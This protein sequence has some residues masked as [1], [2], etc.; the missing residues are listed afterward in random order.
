MTHPVF[1]NKFEDDYDPP[2]ALPDDDTKQDGM[3]D[4]TAPIIKFSNV[5]DGADGLQV[6]MP[7]NG[8]GGLPDWFH[9]LR[10][11]PPDNQTAIYTRPTSFER[12]SDSKID[13]A[14]AIR[15]GRAFAMPSKANKREHPTD[16]EQKATPEPPLHFPSYL[17]PFEFERP[18]SQD[19]LSVAE[20]LSGLQS[21][22]SSEDGAESSLEGK[23][24]LIDRAYSD[25]YAPRQSIRGRPGL[26]PSGRVPAAS[27]G[28]RSQSAGQRGA[29]RGTRSWLTFHSS[30][31]DLSRGD[32]WG[33]G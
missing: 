17:P 11:S 28:G 19:T 2:S 6:Y 8:S 5:Y 10:I 24:P 25:T 7:P 16:T 3:N 14:E 26:N 23:K 30:R 29:G 13:S 12:S 31:S 18:R 4:D 33:E 22:N 15:R 9:Q 1:H 21:F 20:Q 27:G 32:G